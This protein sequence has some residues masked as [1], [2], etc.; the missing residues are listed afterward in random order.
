MITTGGRATSAV[1]YATTDRRLD[2]PPR[3]DRLVR[4]AKTAR[5]RSSRTKHPPSKPTRIPCSW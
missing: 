2:T 5:R 4:Q 1:G 3:G